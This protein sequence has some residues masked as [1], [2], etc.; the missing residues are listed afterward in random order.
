MRY[1]R[2]AALDKLRTTRCA[3]RAMV[4]ALRSTRHARRAARDALHLAR[5]AQYALLHALR[6]LGCDLSELFYPAHNVVA[7]V[8][9]FT[10]FFLY[11]VIHT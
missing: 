7:R 8:L 10:Q 11:A 3:R 6:S 5:C 1:A 2:R 9:T 4:A